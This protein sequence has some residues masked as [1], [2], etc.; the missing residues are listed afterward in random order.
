MPI[1]PRI[2]RVGVEISGGIRWY[3]GVQ[4]SAQGT[5]YANPMQ[6]EATVKITNMTQQ[7]RDFILTET[8]PFNRNRRRK[9]LII[10][11]GRVS[12]GYHRLFVGDIVS[13]TISQ[14]PD[15]I[16][17]MTAKT[18]QFDKGVIVGQSYAGQASSLTI[19]Q[20]VADSMGLKLIHEAPPKNIANYNFTGATVKQVDRLG[21]MGD[22]N[23]YIDD[24]KLIVKER[25]KPLKNSDHVLSVDNGMVG[26]PEITDQGVKVT[27]MLTPSVKLGGG[28]TI[29]SKLNPAASGAFTIYKLMFDVSNRDI[30]FY[31]IVEAKKH[32]FLL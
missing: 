23:A 30:P 21:E 15:I 13:A 28:I 22:V 24:D 5:K 16:L 12:T 26:I 20:G 10:E 31:T 3:E 29:K 8:S 25:N 11:A 17:T 1:D 9:K 2:V 6:N 14:P 7:A 4:I 27:M 18:G 19:A 32:G